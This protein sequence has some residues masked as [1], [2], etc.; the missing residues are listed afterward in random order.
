[1]QEFSSRDAI[2]EFKVDKGTYYLPAFSVEDV[3]TVS[4]LAALSPKEQAAQFPKVIA[5]RAR[6]HRGALT[7]LLLGWRAPEEAVASLS[8]AQAS[9]LFK[10]WA[11]SAGAPLGE[12]SSSAG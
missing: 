11:A 9:E 4:N 5:A 7:R 8:L 2:H 6:C 10:G 12:S 3:E 1:M